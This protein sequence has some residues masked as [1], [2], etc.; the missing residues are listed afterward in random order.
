M[1]VSADWYDQEAAGY[2]VPER[3]VEAARKDRERLEAS[4]ADVSAERRAELEEFSARMRVR[5]RAFI[6]RVISGEGV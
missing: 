2:D 6:E 1:T 4:L 3:W 5:D